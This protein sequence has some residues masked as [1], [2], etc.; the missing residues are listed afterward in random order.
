MTSLGFTLS[1]LLFV[2]GFLTLGECR[3]AAG[4]SRTV[5][6]GLILANPTGVSANFKVSPRNSIDG[7][8][9]FD[10]DPHLHGTY[11]FQQYDAIQVNNYKFDWYAGLGARLRFRKER[12]A[13]LVDSRKIH[14][15]PRFSAG[16][17]FPISQR[18]FDAFAEIAP[19]VE[20][21]P[22]VEV[23]FGFALGARI[24]F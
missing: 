20:L 12:D 10:S 2:T 21:V 14:L 13:Q 3:A 8:V 7:A 9:A 22:R 5:G 11:L 15:G 18:Q 16:L 17:G 23:D 19:T 24:Y 1:I 6:V 4:N